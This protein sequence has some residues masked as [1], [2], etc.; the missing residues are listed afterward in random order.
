M[1]QWA[2]IHAKYT[3]QEDLSCQRRN[4]IGMILSVA[5]DEERRKRQEPEKKDMRLRVGSDWL[6]RQNPSHSVK[7]NALEERIAT[8]ELNLAAKNHKVQFT[9]S[10]RSTARLARGLFQ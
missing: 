9:T 3:G 1:Q 6:I 5:R 2:T 10:R 8:T 4:S 7:K